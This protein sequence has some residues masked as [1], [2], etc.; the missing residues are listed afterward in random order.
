M[1]LCQTH[2][3]P[4]SSCPERL[5]PATSGKIGPIES[6]TRCCVLPSRWPKS[7]SI[8]HRRVWVIAAVAAVILLAVLAIGLP[9]LQTMTRSF[10]LQAVV[11][12]TATPFTGTVSETQLAEVEASLRSAGL[13]DEPILL[14][15]GIPEHLRRLQNGEITAEALLAYANHLNALRTASAA[16]GEPIPSTFWDVQTDNMRESGLTEYSIAEGMALPGSA[17]Y[18]D[19][20]A[21]AYNRLLVLHQNSATD[22]ALDAAF[23]I[24]QFV[25]DYY[26]AISPASDSDQQEQLAHRGNSLI[27]IW[28]QVM[29]STSRTNPLNREQ[30]ISHSIFNHF[31]I[32][33]MYRYRA[34]EYLSI[35]DIWGVSGF[36]GRFVGDPEN[37]NQV[38]HVTISMALQLVLEDPLAALNAIEDRAVLTGSESAGHANADKAVNTAIARDFAPYFYSD[39][40][41]GIEHL[42]CILAGD[43]TCPVPS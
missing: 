22:T 8:R 29:F 40:R 5:N 26:D 33:D 30:L 15:T 36:A 17:L 9:L 24:F 28:H 4:V 34:G 3:Q 23:D 18:L 16:F 7:L 2:S 32:T 27:L 19:L 20:L 39:F 21:H 25:V 12:P 37:D 42:R 43:E 14:S 41:T 11:F 13:A 1:A 10:D 38:E 31:N 35:G 6:S